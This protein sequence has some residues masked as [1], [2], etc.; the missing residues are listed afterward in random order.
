MQ[1]KNKT[2]TKIV[3][4]SSHHKYFKIIYRYSTFIQQLQFVD[5]L[6]LSCKIFDPASFVDYRNLERRPFL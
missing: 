6:P 5:Y 2:T 3:R 1:N 4:F